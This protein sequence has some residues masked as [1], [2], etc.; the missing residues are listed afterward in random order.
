MDYR[1]SAAGPLGAGGGFGTRLTRTGWIMVA[2][3]GVCY[4][5]ALFLESW[6]S[7]PV[8][9]TLSLKALGDPAHNILHQP[10][11]LIT[12]HLLHPQVAIVDT[13][14]GLVVVLLVAALVDAMGG[15]LGQR[16]RGLFFTLAMLGIL[17]L[18]FFTRR[19]SQSLVG[20]PTTLLMLYFFSAPVE[21][22]LGTRR[23]ITVWVLTSLGAAVV[24]QPLS[25]VYG[26]DAPFVGP[27]PSLMA[28]IVLFGLVNRNAQILMMLVL[29]VRA[30]WVSIITAL[31]AVLAVL[32]KFHP[33]A[34]YWCGGIAV[35]F[36]FY[37]GWL[38]V[39]DI[40]L[41]ALRLKQW[42]LKRKLHRFTVIEGGRGR[43]DD[44]KP[45][46]H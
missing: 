28:L 37:R 23:F 21:N 6:F 17:A 38:D 29:P 35:G 12:H 1:Y 20:F 46:Y 19:F 25:L 34:G 36:L 27:M 39:F 7:V 4:A 8:Y 16:N 13:V 43:D 26:F 2:I 33:A 14:L 41:L 42:Q 30:I 31:M 5:L 15:R 10:W 3:Y 18:L 32:A 45:V 44:D 9:D 40:K 22:Y 24:G 11:R